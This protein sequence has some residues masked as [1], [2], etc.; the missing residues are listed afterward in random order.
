MLCWKTADC[1]LWAATEL[2]PP[3]EGDEVSQVLVEDNDA[4]VC[5]GEEEAAPEGQDLDLQV[6]LS[7]F[8]S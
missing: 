6:N 4:Q 8:Q 7:H 3:A 5:H 2:L 1:S